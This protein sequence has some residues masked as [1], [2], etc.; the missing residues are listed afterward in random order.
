MEE[1][2]TFSR[3]HLR[4]YL[5]FFPSTQ[6]FLRCVLAVDA[7]SVFFLVPSLCIV[8][9]F[10]YSLLFWVSIEVMAVVSVLPR[11]QVSLTVTRHTWN[12]PKK[13]TFFILFY[14]NSFRDSEQ[15]KTLPKTYLFTFWMMS[16]L[17]NLLSSL[18]RDKEMKAAASP[19]L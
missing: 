1:V 12:F 18:G 3:T 16:I 19:N 17:G 9:L 15:K 8:C 13:E 11:N 6:Y 2:V 4:F 5:V 7:I 10:F 14:D